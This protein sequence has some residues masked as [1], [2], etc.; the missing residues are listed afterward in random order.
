LV[1]GLDNRPELR[2]EHNELDFH[3]AQDQLRRR[4]LRPQLAPHDLA[5]RRLGLAIVTLDEVFLRA[6]KRLATAAATGRALAPAF[7][8]QRRRA[9]HR[10]LSDLARVSGRRLFNVVGGWTGKVAFDYARHRRIL[11]YRK[12]YAR[13]N[14]WPEWYTVDENT[15][16]TVKDPTSDK[17]EILLGSELKEG[18]T[19][20]AASTARRIITPR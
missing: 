18:L 5:N 15:L 19:L 9:V 12:Y 17:E 8:C 10:R 3:V 14:Q 13:L 7:Q 11:N 20:R 4:V 6:G 16:Y 1:P 2:A